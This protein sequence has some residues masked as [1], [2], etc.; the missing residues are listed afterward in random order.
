MLPRETIKKIRRIEIRTR[1]AVSDLFGGRYR[2]VFKG[3]GM[4]FQEVR[5]YLPGD[6]VRSIDWNVTA[7]AGAPYI[8]KFQEERELTVMLLVDISASN[9][10]GS[11]SQLKRDLAAET[12]AILAFSAIA[13]H[14]R[15]GLILF[16]DRVEK[17][18]PPA[19]GSS[20]ILRLVSEILSAAPASPRA[21]T[22]LSP[23]LLALNHSQRRRTVAF[24]I[25]DFICPACD[26]LLRVA[27]R[28][29]DLTA[30]LV[31]DRLESALPPAGLVHFRDLET[32]RELVLDTSYPPARRALFAR[33]T[34]RRTALLDA[35]HHD[36][37]DTVELYAGEPPDL[38]LIRFFRQREARR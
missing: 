31:A 32:G 20:H 13:N 11:R 10:F 15:V 8:K 37:L 19:K 7:R 17:L 34:A 3:H 6:D 9:R 33:Q 14:D 5:E 24:L 23:A 2:S 30:I 35:L 29:H 36:A 4:E 28:R 18:I 25:S 27:A 16:S 26:N 1:R 22:D 38:P 12:A 21:G